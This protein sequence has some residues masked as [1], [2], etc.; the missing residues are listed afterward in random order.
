MVNLHGTELGSEGYVPGAEA[1]QSVKDV[2]L[3]LREKKSDLIYLLDRTNII[4]GCRGR[5]DSASSRHGGRRQA[6]CITRR[7]PDLQVHAPLLHHHH[8]ELV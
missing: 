4:I 1:L 2:A 3:Y 5:T 6:L 8:P 7:H